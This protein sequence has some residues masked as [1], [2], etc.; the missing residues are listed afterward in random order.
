MKRAFYALYVLPTSRAF[1]TRAPVCPTR[2]LQ[3]ESCREDL[4]YR[5]DVRDFDLS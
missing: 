1:L 5:H 3:L 2:R 4:Q